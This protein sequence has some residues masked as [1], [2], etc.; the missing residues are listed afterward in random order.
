MTRSAGRQEESAMKAAGNPT[1]P[2][3]AAFYASLVL[4]EREAIE[5]SDEMLDG[6]EE[7]DAESTF[8]KGDAV[9]LAHDSIGEGKFTEWCR[10]RWKRHRTY[11]YDHLRVVEKLGP[12]RVRIVRA[13]MQP[14]AVLALS[15]RPDRA[16][17]VLRSFE[18]GER[19]SGARVRA[20]LADPDDA[21]GDH[22]AAKTGGI[23]GL[24][25][26]HAAKRHRLRELVR[27]LEEVIAAVEAALAPA[28]EAGRVFKG[29]LAE[30]IVLPSRH[31]RLEL[32]NL[33]AVLEP[34][35][36]DAAALRS[37]GFAEGSRWGQVS[38]LLYE[39]GGAESWPPA[40][41]LEPWLRTRVLPVLKWAAHGDEEG[42]AKS[43]GN[44]VSRNAR[45]GDQPGKP[46]RGSGEPAESD[47]AGL[48]TRRQG[49]D[50]GAR[51]GEPEGSARAT[52][53]DEDSIRRV[54]SVLS[55][56]RP[57]VGTD[58]AAAAAVDQV[59]HR[60]ATAIAD[61]MICGKQ[62]QEFPGPDADERG[63]LAE[64]LFRGSLI[65]VA[66]DE[67]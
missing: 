36:H 55:R 37:A 13:R 3:A 20:M 2:D 6:A 24:E 52:R 56:L 64:L 11:A 45:H 25:R 46:S 5:K 66:D 14:A 58:R 17:E 67:H 60:T 39:I 12:L 35:P 33:C 65:G 19:P 32:L 10:L 38:D 62:V 18:T 51:P 26:L 1:T 22:E 9:K 43:R 50:A 44:T 63:R 15:S 27:R 28:A 21:A 40:V 16:E 47:A 49:E 42:K 8:V 31:A 41:E 7:G 57:D 30:A 4:A 53:F 54:A 59:F 61:L 48:G 29:A 23:R 34:D